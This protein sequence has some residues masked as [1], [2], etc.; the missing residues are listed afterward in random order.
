MYSPMQIAWKFDLN[1]NRQQREILSEKANNHIIITRE[2]RANK[3]TL[4]LAKCEQ[5]AKERNVE[6]IL[7]FYDHSGIVLRRYLEDIKKLS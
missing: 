1:L 4:L 3:T 7:L 6:K 2:S 5:F